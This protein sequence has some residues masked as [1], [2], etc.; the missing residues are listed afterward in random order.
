MRGNVQ[1]ASLGRAQ[2]IAVGGTLYFVTSPLR[3][4]VEKKPGEAGV[5]DLAG[6]TPGAAVAQKLATGPAS[7]EVGPPDKCK[8]QAPL[9]RAASGPSVDGKPAER[10]AEEMARPEEPS[11]EIAKLQKASASAAVPAEVPAEQ[12][13]LTVG[14]VASAG[15]TIDP[16]SVLG[17]RQQTREAELPAGR[18][19]QIEPQQTQ[20]MYRVLFVLRVVGP[21]AQE[22]R[23]GA[24]KQQAV[25]PADAPARPEAK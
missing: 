9:M 3:G 23:A 15:A 10:Y 1:S 11:P 13:Q 8:G 24:T 18:P 4:R 2:R 14:R 17:Q 6:L 19:R 16:Q 12:L 7:A 22:R 20:Q 21:D 25:T 5:E